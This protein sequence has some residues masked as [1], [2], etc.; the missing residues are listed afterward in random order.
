[1]PTKVIVAYP[2]KLR[3]IRDEAP[4]VPKFNVDLRTSGFDNVGA[5][6]VDVMRCMM[7]S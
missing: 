3:G 2:T 7:S 4:A 1:M 5:D 6:N